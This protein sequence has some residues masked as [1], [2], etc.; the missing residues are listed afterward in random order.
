VGLLNG[1]KTC[2]RCGAALEGD[3]K[4]MR[5]DSCGS[6]YYAHSAPAASAIVVDEEGRVLLARRK[7][8]PDAGLWDTPGGFL[9]EGEEPLAGLRRELREETG[10]EVEPRRFLGAYMD[11]YGEGPEAG[12][13]LNLV[14][15]ASIVS[16]E[17]RAADDVS[18]VRWFAPDELPAEDEF[19]FRWIAPFMR[20]WRESRLG[21]SKTKG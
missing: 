3:E 7:F 20:R 17:M 6:G 10:L 16:G 8:E 15:E 1:W 4:T 14:W 9:E 2:P 21:V 12:S 11:T 13:V 18:E 19:A 5:C